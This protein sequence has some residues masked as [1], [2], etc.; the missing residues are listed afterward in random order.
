VG[1]WGKR[2]RGKVKRNGVGCL[3]RGDLEGKEHLKCK[4]M[5]SLIIKK[6]YSNIYHTV[7]FLYWARE[8]CLPLVV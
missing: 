1:G 4:Q 7:S 6:E 8:V 3:W 5:K 2:E